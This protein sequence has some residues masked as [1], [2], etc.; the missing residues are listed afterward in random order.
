MCIPVADITW[1]AYSAAAMQ[2]VFGDDKWAK[3]ASM[4]LYQ[5]ALQPST[6]KNY[7]SALT[8]FLNFC[9]ETMVDPL[10]GTPLEI[11]RYI[12]WIGERG[13]V[14]ARSLQPY[15]SAINRFLANHARAPMALA[16]LVTSGRTGLE[17]CQQDLAPSRERVPLPAPVVMAILQLAKRLLLVVHRDYSDQRLKLLRA[18]VAS[19]ASCVFFNRGECNC[20]GV[21]SEDMVVNDTHIT[22]LL[23]GEKGKKARNKG[24]RFV[25]QI[26]V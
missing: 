14:A 5:A 7:G 8:G 3:E 17:K 25:R 9:E 20:S 16:P 1:K 23:R 4:A 18:S 22:L 10:E 19:I 12:A 2:L 26:A 15:L 21:L 6:Y 13:T 11:A 24:Q